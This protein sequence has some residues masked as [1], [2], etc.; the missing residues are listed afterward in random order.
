M[1]EPGAAPAGLW[2]LEG[3]P[4]AGKS[5]LLRRWRAASP[6]PV[7]WSAEDL[8]SQRI[9]EPL[10]TQHRPEVVEPWLHG[11]LDAWEALQSA[12]ARAP[13]AARRGD[14]AAHQERFHLSAALEGGLGPGAFQALEARLAA[15]G[16][17][18]LLLRLDEATLRARIEASLAERPASWAAWLQRRYGGPDGALRAFL[19][20]QM[21]LEALAKRSRLEW[22]LP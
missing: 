18:G 22:R 3:V 2:I 4:L 13:W 15:L 19:D 11:L 1:T 7:L 20:Q 14:F 21:E 17:R 6:A 10:E 5:S 9:F 8:A 16:A 12:A